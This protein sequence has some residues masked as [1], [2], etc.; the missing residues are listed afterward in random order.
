MVFKTFTLNFFFLQQQKPI[1]LLF[2]Q[3]N[4]KKRKTCWCFAAVIFNILWANVEI[5]KT[6]FVAFLYALT[7]LDVTH[8][9]FVAVVYLLK[10]YLRKHLLKETEV[11]KLKLYFP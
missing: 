11:A 2:R 10:R 5:Y 4:D 6:E 7:P 9:L 3:N 1:C 8:G